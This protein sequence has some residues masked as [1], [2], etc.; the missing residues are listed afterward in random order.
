MRKLSAL[1]CFLAVN[2]YGA[3]YTLTF[4]IDPNGK[5]SW[6]QWLMEY[7]GRAITVDSRDKYMELATAK[8]NV[9]LTA[10]AMDLHNLYGKG[11]DQEKYEK[12]LAYLKEARVARLELKRLV[13]Q[14][15]R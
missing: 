14:Y 7:R 10:N 15:S 6:Q 13:N 8:A 1:L 12:F 3:E 9:I 2:L 5:A 4:D 11:T